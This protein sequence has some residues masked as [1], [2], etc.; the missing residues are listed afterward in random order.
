MK[1]INLVTK[2]KQRQLYLISGPE[3]LDEIKISSLIPKEAKKV[4]IKTKQDRNSKQYILEIDY[5]LC[6]DIKGLKPETIKE[7]VEKWTRR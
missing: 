5:I 3:E 4:E 7:E 2:V 6:L 1:P